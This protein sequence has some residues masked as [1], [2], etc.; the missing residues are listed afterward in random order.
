MAKIRASG[1]AAA[2]VKGQREDQ[3]TPAARDIGLPP[4]PPKW[5]FGNP[6]AEIR[7]KPRRDGVIW[8]R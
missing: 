8:H 2:I 3:R 4:P 5:S 6:K 1:I 7:V